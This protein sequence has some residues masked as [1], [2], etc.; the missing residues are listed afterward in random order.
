MEYT[1]TR[2][3]PHRGRA[4]SPPD[5]N[6]D[7]NY[8]I[9]QTVRKNIVLTKLGDLI[10]WGRKNSLWPYNFG[11][12]YYLRAMLQLYLRPRRASPFSAPRDWALGAGGG[13]L[14]LL[15]LA[16]LALGFYPGPFLSLVQAAGLTLAAR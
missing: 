11:L 6:H 14:T 3:D 5:V 1:L 15:L 2:I 8:I 16:M 12:Y 13:V 7:E 10:N 4:P 9:E